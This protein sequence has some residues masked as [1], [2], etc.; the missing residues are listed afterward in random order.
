MVEALLVGSEHVVIGFFVFV[1]MLVCGLVALV[2]GIAAGVEWGNRR[3]RQR[4]LD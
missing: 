4:D 3:S 1:A 2:S